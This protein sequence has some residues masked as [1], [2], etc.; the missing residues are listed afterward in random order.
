MKAIPD[1]PEE[2]G[3]QLARAEFISK[4]L[5]EQVPDDNLND[6]PGSGRPITIYADYSE[7]A[8]AGMVHDAFDLDAGSVEG[9]QQHRPCSPPAAPAKLVHR[10]SQSPHALLVDDTVGFQPEQDVVTDAAAAAA[11]AEMPLPQLLLPPK[12]QEIPEGSG[13]RK[14]PNS[15][16]AYI[17]LQKKP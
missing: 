13:A 3:I 9:K 6:V 8:Q 11:A 14:G 17:T 15:G 1:V 10:A 12:A 2:V 16:R 7:L 4:K 5:I